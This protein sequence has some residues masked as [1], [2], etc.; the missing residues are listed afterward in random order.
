M[1]ALDDLFQKQENP[2][3]PPTTRVWLQRI[4]AGE[5]AKVEVVR[6]RSSL[7]YGPTRLRILFNQKDVQLD[8]WDPHVSE[9]LAS[10]KVAAVDETNEALRL[11]LMFAD[12]FQ[13]PASRFGDDYFN[14][15]LVEYVKYGPFGAVPGVQDILRYT[16]E[17]SPS[18]EIRHYVDC[19]NEVVAV[20]QRGAQMLTNIGY[21]RPD[22]ERILV[23]ALVQFLDDRFGVTNRRMLGLL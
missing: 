17:H 23:G 7:S 13:R 15:V 2:D 6:K 21:A 16:H 22:A 11:A 10:E 4:R 1:S 19:R 20:F 3:L 12:W 14:S 8:D 18:K 5:T 9:V